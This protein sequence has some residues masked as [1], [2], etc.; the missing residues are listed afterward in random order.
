M[1]FKVPRTQWR[2]RFGE[3]EIF[4][5]SFAPGSI[6]AKELCNESIFPAKHWVLRSTDAWSYGNYSADR[7]YY[8][9]GFP[10]MDLLVAGELGAVCI[11]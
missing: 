3:Q 2:A 9:G 4:M 10:T 11:I 1:N 6:C 8:H 7:G 5:K